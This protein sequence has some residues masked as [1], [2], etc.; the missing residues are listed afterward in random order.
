MN[1]GLSER[2][3]IL[4]KAARD[5]FQKECPLPLVREFRDKGTLGA[6]P[7][8]KLA[9]LGWL[10]LAIPEEYGGQG[11]SFL[12]LSVSLLEEAGRALFPF[13]LTETLAGGAMS[14]IEAGSSSAKAQLLSR[15]VS[16]K[17][18]VTLAL[19]D[20]S[21]DFDPSSGALGAARAESGYTLHGARS[22]V[23]F[24]ADAELCIVAARTNGNT[25]EDGIT[26]FAVDLR[27]HGMTIERHRSVTGRG[28]HTLMFDE[29]RVGHERV[30]GEPGDGWAVVSKIACFD[31]IGRCSI[32]VGSARRMLELTVEMAKTRVQFGQPIGSF[33]S[34]QHQCADMLISVDGM[35]Y[36][37]YQAASQLSQKRNCDR[38]VAIARVYCSDSHKRVAESAVRIHGAVGFTRDHE[39]GLHFLIAQDQELP[40][41]HGDFYR[42]AIAREVLSSG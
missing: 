22:L 37:S 31:A 24:A 11:S 38:Q 19:S 3:L 29:T 13:P 26:V 7:W 32:A 8:Q 41:D 23:P 25:A 17:A 35:Q 21:G 6:E 18:M 10:G 9:E 28:L 20:D 2:Q 33:Q 36:V 34:I 15:I 4:K 16:G 30:I 42:R 39:V 12:D 14:I 27:S 1:L 5:F 40:L